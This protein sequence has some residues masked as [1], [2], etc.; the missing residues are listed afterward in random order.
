MKMFTYKNVL[1]LLACVLGL[2]VQAEEGQPAKQKR[3][4]LHDEFTGQGYGMAGCGLGS[5]IFG[6]KPGM[7]QIFAGTTNSFSGSQTFG[8]SSGTSNCG[9]SSKQNQASEFIKVNK[10]AIETEIARG[11]GESLLALAEILNCKNSNFPSEMKK[12][13]NETLSKDVVTVAQLE[14]VTYKVCQ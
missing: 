12:T 5:I 4:T 1:V 11:E 14:T 7:I 10:V 2:S 8:V 9:E 3:K 6:D 13:Y